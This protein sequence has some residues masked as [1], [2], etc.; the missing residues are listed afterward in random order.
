MVYGGHCGDLPVARGET[1]PLQS[2][3]RLLL[4]SKEAFMPRIVH[5]EIHADQ[6]ERAIRFYT[7]VLGWSFQKW[8]GPMPY[9]MVMTGEGPGI[10][11]GLMPRQGPPPADGAACNCYTCVVDTDNVDA[12]TA[13]V[14]S[15]GGKCVV[16]KM[17]I[18]GVGYVAYYKDTEGNIFGAMQSDEKAT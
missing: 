4:A 10:D 17:T 11:G 13:K 18:P 6:P 3:V 2:R 15:A 9:Y 12:L 8:D 16:P 7:T 5:F 14:A 1:A